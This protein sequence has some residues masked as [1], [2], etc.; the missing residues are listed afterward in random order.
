M[1]SI[2]KLI[3]GGLLA[4]AVSS[5]LAADGQAIYQKGG[6]NPGAIACITCHGPEGMGMDAGG[7]PHISGYPAEYLNKQIHDFRSGTRQNPIMLPIANGLTDE[8]AL[9]VSQYIASMK[10][11]KT[12]EVTRAKKPEGEGETL[13]LRGDWTRNIPECVV[14]HGP[15]GVGVG[16]SFPP[17]AGQHP[18][19]LKN[20]LHAWKNGTRKNDHA[21]LMGHIA[22]ALTESEIDAIAQYFSGLGK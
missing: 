10:T 12:P 1:R 22:R 2:T 19:Y 7:F 15:G 4:T 20:Q 18:S 16:T 13:A 8:E 17:L 9:A 6:S 11:P 21:D 3:C 14:C 5:A